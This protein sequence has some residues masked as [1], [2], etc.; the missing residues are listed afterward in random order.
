MIKQVI[1]HVGAPKTGSTYLQ[2]RLRVNTLTLLNK[3]LYYP[4]KPGFEKVAANA[5]LVTLAIDKNLSSGFS[6]HFPH[7]DVTKLDPNNEFDL[8]VDQ[9]PGNTESVILSSEKMRPH[10]ARFIPAL[11]KKGVSCK[12][13]QFIR[14]QDDW[15][16]SYCSQL[17]KNNNFGSIELALDRIMD[18]SESPF[19]CP[20]WLFHHNEWRKHF[21]D[22]R[23]IFFDNKRRPFFDEFV[24]T[25][26][27]ETVTD[28]QEIGRANESLSLNEL[29]YLGS[30]SSNTPEKVFYSHRRACA[31]VSRK[32]PQ[33]PEKFSF[34]S[35]K[36]RAAMIAKV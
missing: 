34:L 30:F 20:D 21:D 2:K 12:V 15:M 27:F 16:D 26:G 5:K 13:V 29:T 7:I 1:F 18:S 14:K 6:R 19:C 36:Q 35:R 8:L 33:K 28:F 22:F 3:N 10:H 25:I 32:S 31:K 9:C 11:I 4:V 24:K 23:V 17:I